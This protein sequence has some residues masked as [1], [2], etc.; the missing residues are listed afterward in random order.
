MK[1]WLLL[2]N[3]QTA[4]AGF[5]VYGKYIF[6]YLEISGV[7]KQIGYP[8]ITVLSSLLPDYATIIV[9]REVL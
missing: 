4:K 9:L 2:E 3:G 7:Q 6:Y 8:F 5:S 1:A